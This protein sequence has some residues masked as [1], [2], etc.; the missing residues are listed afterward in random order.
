MKMKGEAYWGRLNG[1]RE[2]PWG[3]LDNTNLE[4]KKSWAKERQLRIFQHKRPDGEPTMGDRTRYLTD[5]YV[6]KLMDNAG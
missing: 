5:F 3:G 4:D 6:I 1:V 2:G